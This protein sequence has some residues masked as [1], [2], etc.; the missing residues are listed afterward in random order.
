MMVRPVADAPEWR[1]LWNAKQLLSPALPGES[2]AP[3]RARSPLPD[4]IS[5]SPALRSEDGPAAALQES[6]RR[7]RDPGRPLLRRHRRLR[8]RAVSLFTDSPSGCARQQRGDLP[9]S[10]CSPIWTPEEWRRIMATNLDGCFYTCKLAVPSWFTKSG[11]NPQYLLHLGK[12][13]PPPWKPP[14]PPPKA[15][16]TA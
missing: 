10:G 14:I 7:L 15:R 16:S 13:G 9:L 5:S 2:A 3:S 1:F 6:R 11:E 8:N 4:M 12:C